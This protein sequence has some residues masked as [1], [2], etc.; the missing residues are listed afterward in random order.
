MPM[1]LA[2]NGDGSVT[3]NTELV[4]SRSDYSP[5]QAVPYPF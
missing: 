2:I 3:V 1:K 4:S 5:A